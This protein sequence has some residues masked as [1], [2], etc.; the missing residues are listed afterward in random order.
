VVGHIYDLSVRT[1]PA[2]GDV[3]SQV[4]APNFGPPAGG[5]VVVLVHGYNNDQEAASESYA[6]FL[7]D[8]RAAEATI[9]AGAV[10]PPQDFARFYWP[11]DANLW[12]FSFVS[13]P[14]EVRDA[15]DSAAVLGSFLANVP[16]LNEVSFV[17][18]S[19]G[20]RLI[21]DM[22]ARVENGLV[23][24]FPIVR[25][26]L[27]NAAAVPVALVTRGA[28]LAIT[29]GN[30]QTNV[31]VRFSPLDL[32][33]RF[34]FPAGQALA[35]VMGYEFDAY[36]DAVG[37]N[38]EPVDYSTSRQELVGAGHGDYWAHPDIARDVLSL[39]GVAVTHATPRH[40]SPTHATDAHDSP[41]AHRLPGYDAG[42]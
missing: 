42:V 10:G 31:R 35:Y 7:G 20:C 12:I 1:R 36:V 4:G 32:V 38:G 2:G 9:A 17:G 16:G 22:L 28:P 33:L 39:L 21:L 40:Q 3:A 13:Y 24:G 26:L 19:M 34:A 41:A 14:T 23:P 15:S 30:A 37:L 6:V 8:L 5:H 11:G 29:A 18:H 27:L 25:F